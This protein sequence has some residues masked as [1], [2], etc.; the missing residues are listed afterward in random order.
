MSV[1]LPADPAAYVYRHVWEDACVEA[2]NRLFAEEEDLRH[3]FTLGGMGLADGCREMAVALTAVAY[4]CGYRDALD[5]EEARAL[6]D[7]ARDPAELA[8]LLVDSA[9][10]QARNDLSYFD[11]EFQERS[12]ET[13]WELA[14]AAEDAPA[15]KLANNEKT[16]EDGHGH[17]EP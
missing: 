15:E 9:K 7:Q 17:D 14:P 1:E 8:H 3:R 5:D 2:K 6:V 10:E 16:R 13:L 11:E 4:A 12:F